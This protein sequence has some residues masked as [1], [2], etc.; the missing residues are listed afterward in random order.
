MSINLLLDNSNLTTTKKDS[1]SALPTPK[2]EA[3]KWFAWW[4]SEKKEAL[5]PEETER[6]YA[7]STSE[8]L[9]DEE[10]ITTHKALFSLIPIRSY[11]AK[12]LTSK[13]EKLVVRLV[14]TGM[15]G[16]KEDRAWLLEEAAR[17]RCFNV[18]QMVQAKRYLEALTNQD[19]DEMDQIREDHSPL[20][21]CA[22]HSNR[23]KDALALLQTNLADLKVWGAQILID[24]C[25]N[26]DMEIIRYLSDHG[27]NFRGEQSASFFGAALE[28]PAGRRKEVIQ[29]LMEKGADVKAVD[30]EGNTLF[31]QC[32]LKCIPS[33]E[34][35]EIMELL[36]TAGVDIHGINFANKS[37]LDVAHHPEFIHF[38]MEHGVT[39][40]AIVEALVNAIMEGKSE[41]I[42]LLAK[43][44]NVYEKSGDLSPYQRALKTK[45]P[46]IVA[47]L[48]QISEQE[49]GKKIAKYRKE[50]YLGH[51]NSIE[52]SEHFNYEGSN[53]KQMAE[54]I[55]KALQTLPEELSSHISQK[56]KEILVKAYQ[57]A[58]EC[59]LETIQKGDLAIMPLGFKDHTIYLIFCNGYL[60]ICN[61]GWGAP[62]RDETVKAFKIDLNLLTDEILDALS[63]LPKGDRDKSCKYYYETLPWLLSPTGKALSDAICTQLESLS[64]DFQKS[65]N[66]AF[67]QA[68]LG[69]RVAL[70]MTK[71]QKDEQGGATLKKG[72][73]KEAKAFSKDL[74][75]HIR[76]SALNGY[77]K[78]HEAGD[79]NESLVKIA[80]K[81]VRRRF[82]SMPKIA[83]YTE[84][85]KWRVRLEESQ[86]MSWSELLKQIG[87]GII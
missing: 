74:S 54:K 55:A 86:K 13:K 35:L 43:G 85:N 70:A 66:C 25:R 52:H 65:G 67:A 38:F 27:V 83:L 41:K 9:S 63:D 42:A 81:K 56:D 23:D 14:E 61:R 87:M 51:V 15:V 36:F 18:L 10:F 17:L 1:D 68:K 37:S 12:L 24:A 71:I 11:L 8:E 4:A 26:G 46:K 31:M 34:T 59:N 64:P 32:A 22:L 40:K 53:P 72:D 58:P 7:I 39:K 19:Q 21:I 6:V 47:T 16:F 82:W 60:T 5:T 84:I 69:A 49:A 62:S 44:V 48:L 78:K 45:N 73:L 3:K 50:F 79:F 2:S 77:L 76:L 20:I 30:D 33:A 57:A 75:S 29:L 80:Y 28:A